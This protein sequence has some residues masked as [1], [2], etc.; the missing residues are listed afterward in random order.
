MIRNWRYDD[1]APVY[2]TVLKKHIGEERRPAWHCTIPS[3]DID[4]TEIQRWLEEN[5]V[6]DEQ[7]EITFRFNSGDPAMFVEIYDKDA[8]AMFYLAWGP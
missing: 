6:E 8:A 2:S 3:R 5:L 1:G 4:A 7:F